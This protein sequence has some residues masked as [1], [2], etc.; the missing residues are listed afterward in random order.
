M[1]EYSY[2]AKNLKILQEPALKNLHADGRFRWRHSVDVWAGMVDEYLPNWFVRIWE[3]IVSMNYLHC[4]HPVDRQHNNK[5]KLI[6]LLTLVLRVAT[7][8]GPHSGPSSGSLIK[9]VSCYWTVLIWTHITATRHSHI[10]H[11]AATKL[12]EFL[13]LKNIPQF[14]I[15]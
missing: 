1:R 7:C 10:V 5:N 14:K 15:I 13:Y 11:A 2:G 4:L 12:Q 6:E 9:Y 8:F 3:Q